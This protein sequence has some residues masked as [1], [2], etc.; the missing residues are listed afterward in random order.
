MLETQNNHLSELGKQNIYNKNVENFY[1]NLWYNVYM[2]T[3]INT[4]NCSNSPQLVE[5]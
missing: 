4:Q 1:L 2:N 3:I 5:I